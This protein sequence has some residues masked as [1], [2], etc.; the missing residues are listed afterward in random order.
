MGVE[1]ASNTIANAIVKYLRKD[2]TCYAYY[3]AHG[4]GAHVDVYLETSNGHNMYITRF[5][6]VIGF[7]DA[8]YAPNGAPAGAIRRA[9]PTTQGS[10]QPAPCG[11][12]AGRRAGW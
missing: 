6:P 2:T 7:T 3:T 11:Y 5:T 10:R 4:S 1:L 9:A 8:N 12:P